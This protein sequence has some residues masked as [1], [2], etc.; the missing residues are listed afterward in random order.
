MCLFISCLASQLMGSARL[1]VGGGQTRT[2][3]LFQETLVI[4]FPRANVAGGGTKRPF[5][6]SASRPD[7][8]QN[9]RPRTLHIKC[10]PH[11]HVWCVWCGYAGSHNHG[12]HRR[13][14][15]IHT[16]FWRLILEGHE[17]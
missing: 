11:V 15:K 10:I 5:R 1:A 16:L 4:H 7:D 8:V 17:K 9:A 2:K 12:I 14:H 6:V 13:V 3:E